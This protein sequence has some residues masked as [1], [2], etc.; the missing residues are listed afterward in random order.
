MHSS[1]SKVMEDPVIQSFDLY[2]N[3]SFDGILNV[4]Q[5]AGGTADSQISVTELDPVEVS[6]KAESGLVQ[7]RLPIKA[8]DSTY[9][10][11]KATELLGSPQ[12]DSAEDG[13]RRC[14]TSYLLA[15]TPTA[16]A[17]DPRHNLDEYGNERD[18]GECKGDRAL[19]FV[20][21]V[22]TVE[23]ER[24]PSAVFLTPVERFI[25]LRP[26]LDYIDA[27]DAKAKLSARR[28]PAPFPHSPDGAAAPVNNASQ[29]EGLRSV[30]VATRRRETSEQAQARLSSFSYLQKKINDEP[31]NEA[32]LTNAQTGA[33]VPGFSLSVTDFI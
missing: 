14:V 13:G 20:C 25:T 1:E 32:Y 23:D 26:H 24:S 7:L 21:K 2:M 27:A 3:R 28:P 6:F 31:W 19:S 29:S 17:S 10:H 30:N 18:S 4:I 16:L 22:Q 9:S 12:I 5:Y 33:N 11:L 15:G 8:D